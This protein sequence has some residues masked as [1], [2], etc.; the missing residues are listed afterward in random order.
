MPTLTP[1]ANLARQIPPVLG[2]VEI[3]SAGG[4]GD[5]YSDLPLQLEHVKS[6]ADCIVCQSNANSREST[7]RTFIDSGASEHCWAERGDF[8]SFK[9]VRGT[10][11]SSAIAGDAGKFE[12]QGVGTVEFGTRAGGV[13]RTIRLEGV[14]YTPSFGHNLISLSALDRRGFMGSW[15]RGTLSVGKPGGTIILE[16]VGKGRMY[17]VQTIEP[18]TKANSARSHEKAVDIGTWHRRL[19]HVSI[20]RILRMASKN[21]VDG[22][23]IKSK[24]VLGMCEACLYGKATRRPFDEKV[25]HE[26]EVLERVHLDLF[27]PARTRSRGGAEYMMLCT[28]GGS[29]MRVPYFLP[30]KRANT[31]LKEFHRYRAMVLATVL[32]Y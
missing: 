30:D 28:D 14:K 7:A 8:T 24:K 19:A 26:T 29:A 4:S 1:D 12:I 18:P 3:R 22:L 17:E 32:N 15:G 5:V 16:G 23:H 25:V 27:G 2:N 21:L 6:S 13:Y 31:M 10:Y 9:E 20:P 11:G